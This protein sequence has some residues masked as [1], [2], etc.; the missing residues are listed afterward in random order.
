MLSDYMSCCQFTWSLEYVHLT[1][2]F[3]GLEYQI[4]SIVMF[5]GINM[6]NVHFP[7]SW[8]AALVWL[9]VN[10]SWILFTSCTRVLRRKQPCDF[11]RESVRS[12][13]SLWEEEGR[14][15]GQF[16]YTE[17]KSQQLLLLARVVFPC[18]K[19]GVLSFGA[20]QKMWQWLDVENIC[21]ETPAAHARGAPCWPPQFEK[22][23]GRSFHSSPL[24]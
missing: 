15:R 6:Q 2:M 22:I 19:E 10:M 18:V 16:C 5:C 9:E 8:N 3:K 1:S 17:S 12:K 23:Q 7:L 21:R 24:S 20:F 11:S 14:G 4:F 13:W